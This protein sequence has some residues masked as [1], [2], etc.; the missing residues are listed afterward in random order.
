MQERLTISAQEAD[1]DA[2]I[3]KA[4][5]KANPNQLPLF[6]TVESPAQNKETILND[7]LPICEVSIPKQKSSETSEV[8]STSNEKDL[9]PYWN[10]LCGVISSRLL[11]PI[12]ID[13]P[14]SVPTLYA[15]SLSKTVAN[16]WFWAKQHIVRKKNSRRIFSKSCTSSVADCTGSAVTVTKSKKIRVYPTTEQREILRQWFGTA[17]F[18]YNKTV[19]VIVPTT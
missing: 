16:S 8:V 6:A 12:G 3:L 13:S 14:D 15:T 2:M 10:G 9:E 7:K 5:S 11:L 4:T 17:R 18:T 1:T 19:A